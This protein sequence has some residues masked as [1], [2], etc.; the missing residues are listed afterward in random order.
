M[1]KTLIYESHYSN[2]ITALRK[3]VTQEGFFALYKGNG[4]QMV[5]VFPYAAVQFTSYELYK[6]VRFAF[7]ILPGG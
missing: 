3:I 7:Y 1:Y 5:R 4:A 2:A 6:K